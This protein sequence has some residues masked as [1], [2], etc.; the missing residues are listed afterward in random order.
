MGIVTA[1]STLK[2]GKGALSPK[3]QNLD[4]GVHDDEVF[5]VGDD[6]DDD[7]LDPESE[8]L[9]D[10]H[11]APSTPPPAYT[12]LEQVRAHN[13]EEV[14]APKDAETS[15]ALMVPS[16]YYIQPKDTLIGIALRFGVDVSSLRLSV[17]L[18]LTC[19]FPR[20]D[21]YAA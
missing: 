14:S 6:D 8:P 13:N 1:R 15:E 17:V 2:T 20:V 5:A 10:N 16:E 18:V 7:E 3:H 19:V 12:E 9:E 4:G 21:Y 11:A